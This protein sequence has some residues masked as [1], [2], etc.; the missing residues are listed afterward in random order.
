MGIIENIKK[1]F[2]SFRMNM[3][4]IAE[5]GIIDFYKTKPSNIHDLHKEVMENKTKNALERYNNLDNPEIREK[6]DS[7]ASVQSTQSA[8]SDLN[9]GR[10]ILKDESREDIAAR[11]CLNYKQISK[12]ENF[13]SETDINAKVDPEIRD[14]AEREF[15]QE[16]ARS[17]RLGF[18]QEKLSNINFKIGE[19]GKNEL[20]PPTG[21]E[22]KSQ[23]KYN[24]L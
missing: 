17:P 18:L 19:S 13:E 8:P 21:G 5:K 10:K 3:N 16:T 6:R 4:Y 20:K 12:I 23:T 1:R 15:Q 2:N 7:I 14:K 24:T 9:S 22:Q 11:L